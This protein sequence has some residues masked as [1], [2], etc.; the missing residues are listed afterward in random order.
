MIDAGVHGEEARFEHQIQ[1]LGHSPKD[2]SF[3]MLTHGHTD[4]SGT[5]KYFQDKYQIPV[6]CG[7]GD[8][9]LLLKGQNDSL[10]ATNLLGSAIKL[11]VPEK[12]PSLIPDIIVDGEYRL[13][14]FGVD[15]RIVPMEG[16]TDG[17]IALVLEEAAFV[18]DIIRGKA[19]AKKTPELHFF[20]C[21]LEKNE[22]E[23][24]KALTWNCDL[25][26][27]GHFGPLKP[28]RVEKWLASH[29]YH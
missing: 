2:L 23:I 14:K 18:G 8:E 15:G 10:C 17:S 25:W 7:K 24:K 29:P 11:F 13:S 5:A 27:T 1:A 21:D 3:I 4:H 9:E 26:F 28:E 22:K 16:H 6:I 19:M 12:Y 20:Q